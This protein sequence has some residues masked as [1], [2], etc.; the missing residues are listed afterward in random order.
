MHIVPATPEMFLNL[1]EAFS[2]LDI[3]S[4]GLLWWFSS[5]ESACNARDTGWITGSGRP[6]GGEQGNPLQSSCQ[7]N[8]M[9]TGAWQAGGVPCLNPRRGLTLLSPVCRDPAIGV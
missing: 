5:K 9:D 8:P 7:E 3:Y 4:M 6:P 1:S 2:T